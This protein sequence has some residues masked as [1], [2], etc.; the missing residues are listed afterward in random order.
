[1]KTFWQALKEMCSCFSSCF[2]SGHQPS[3]HSLNAPLLAGI[4]QNVPVRVFWKDASG[5][6]LGANALFLQDAQLDNAQALIGKTD[7]DLPW[8]AEQGRA[9]HFDD[10][11]VIF[12]GQPKLMKEDVSVDVNGRMKVWR[13]SKVALFD[14]AGHVIGM[15]GTYEDISDNKHIAADTRPR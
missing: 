5:R 7:F 15:L 8:A 14:Q 6:Y 13:T 3:A 1:M 12:T 9:Y 2:S 4:L 11:E 10:L